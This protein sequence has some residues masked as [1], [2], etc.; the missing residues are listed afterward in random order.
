VIRR[1]V[2]LP[3]SV[4]ALSLVLVACGSTPVVSIA[5]ALT[6]PKEIVDK[7]VTSLVDVKTFEFTGTFTGKLAAAHLGE[8]DLSTI[9]LAG[10]VDVPGK[11]A[12]ISL[13]AP[14]LLGTKLDAVLVGDRA[15]FK[16][17]GALAAVLQGSAEKYTM[18]A[19][20]ATGTDP[21]AI[22]TDVAKLVSQLQAGLAL[23]PV[24]P[25]KAPD[26]RC[27]DLDCYH[28]SLSLTGDQLRALDPSSTLI[29]NTTI[30]LWTRKNDYRPAKIAFS[31][32]S[33]MT[34]TFG[35]S[36]DLRY[37]VG[38]SIAAPPADQIAP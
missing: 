21:L 22:A 3:L 29:G 2:L 32:A 15:Y 24:P 12:R 23:L 34:G 38:V 35:M 4:V 1:L 31:V 8:F 9:K 36:L 18:V 27:G 14:S 20:P 19:V 5:P 25:T 26:E 28:V 6:D 30:D 13:D 16:V 17:A 33:P 7:G 11:G 10:A 37:D